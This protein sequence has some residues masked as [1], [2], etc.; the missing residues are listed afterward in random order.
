MYSRRDFGK[1]AL[2]GIPATA[3]L[4]Q[5][6]KIDSKIAGVQIGTQSYSFRD[7]PL[8]RAIAAI[9]EVGLGECELYAPHV[10]PQAG[11]PAQG[12]SQADARKAAR[13]ALRNW[14][15]TVAPE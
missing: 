15:L 4:A 5:L 11:M 2:A 1:I 12:Q 6:H 10:E 7:L 13:E 8:D 14:R 9:A 3:A